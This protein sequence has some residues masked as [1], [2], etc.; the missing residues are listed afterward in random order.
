[1]MMKGKTTS[2]GL[3][4]AG[5]LIFSGPQATFAQAGTVNDHTI[6]ISAEETQKTKKLIEEY[7]AQ[8]GQPK[9]LE[10]LLEF[11]G[12]NAPDI[13]EARERI[14]LGEAAIAGAEQ[15]QQFNPQ[16]E[17][18]LGVGLDDVGLAK[19]E[20][21][22]KQRLEVAGE[23]GL[24]IDAAEQRKQTLNAEL[25]QAGWDVHQQV[26]R[27]YR[28]GLVDR[29]R[30]RVERDI[31]EFTQ[32][33]FQITEERFEA[34]EEPRTSV[35]VARAEMAKA[36]QRLV[37]A[38]INYIRSLS[39]LGV[40][41]GWNQD[42]PPQPV[43]ELDQTRPIPAK[44]QLVETAYDKD[45]QLAVIEARLEQARAEIALERRK[46]W[47]NPIVG[48]G[49]EAENLNRNDT[50]NK[51]R[52]IIGVP[53]PLWD[54][55][56]GE[57]AAAQTRT[58]IFGQAIDNRR[59]VLKSLVAKQA[60]AVQAASKQAQIY[61][62]EVLPALETQLELLQEGFKLGELSLLDVMNARDRLLAVQR[63]YLDALQQYF[64]AVS[65]LEEL[66]GT[67]I[68]ESKED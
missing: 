63:Q 67:S 41:V 56:Q 68:W 8:I 46:V 33:L 50:Q 2:L 4:F 30:I 45:P 22:L 17:G 26:H 47:P 27:L 7:S 15:F 64:V 42:A 38:W 9:T 49:W 58:Q 5:F 44:V 12:D 43:G 21:T 54:Q 16:I 25:A 28:M 51:L 39:D 52:F 31:L 36:R 48:I 37:Q 20:V 18:E 10:E 53:L 57:I 34:G 40:T 3:I 62:E 11:A 29:R 1:M 6:E 59:H 66:L 60:E 23:R 14:G 24:R 32:Q 55:N 19:A 61:E 13:Q 35:I 65:E